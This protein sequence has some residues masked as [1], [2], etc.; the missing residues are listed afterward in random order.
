[1]DD[2]EKNSVI[3]FLTADKKTVALSN[4]LDWTC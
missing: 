1:M 3:R 2:K 4:K